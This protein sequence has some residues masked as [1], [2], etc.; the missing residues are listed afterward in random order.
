MRPRIPRS[1]SAPVVVRGFL[2]GTPVSR[3]AVLGGSGQGA[4][5]A[6]REH[7][8]APRSPHRGREAASR[9]ARAPRLHPRRAAPGKRGDR[10]RGHRTYR[11]GAAGRHAR[12][13][14][15]GARF[16]GEGRQPG[17]YVPGRARPHRRSGTCTL[18]HRRDRVCWASRVSEG[19]SGPRSALPTAVRR[20]V[21]TGTAPPGPGPAGRRRRGWPTP[22]WT[23]LRGV[24]P[25]RS[26][27][28][29]RSSC[30]RSPQ[31]GGSGGISPTRQRSSRS[32]SA[33][34]RG[35]A[36]PCR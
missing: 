27:A 21:R 2:P 16:R 9:P 28:T 14:R 11:N 18:P 12:G 7:R 33:G 20:P 36:G 4:S 15:R 23:S 22:P 26:A 17:P 25:Q 10:R 6:V 3:E 34:L 30:S 8:R 13:A 32:A 24:L 19:R 1:G 31:D 35:S 5:R 29:R